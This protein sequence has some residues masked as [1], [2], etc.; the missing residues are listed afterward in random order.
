MIYEPMLCMLKRHWLYK[1]KGR[2]LLANL[3]LVRKYATP[4]LGTPHLATPRL[5]PPSHT[6]GRNIIP[7][8][9]KY[10]TPHH[11]TVHYATVR[12]T[13]SHN[14]TPRHGTLRHGTPHHT[15]IYHSTPRHGTPHHGTPR[16]DTPRHAM[17]HHATVHRVTRLVGIPWLVVRI[18]RHFCSVAW[19][20]YERYLVHYSQY[21]VIIFDREQVHEHKNR[22][23]RPRPI[24][25]T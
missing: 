4:R 21:T 5:G 23:Y 12:F 1:Y 8:C 9:N 2:T 16:H 14:G 19:R 20:M 13:T 17:P 22:Q 7:H 24:F 3:G 11:A 6:I 18:Q 10:A 25:A 15:T